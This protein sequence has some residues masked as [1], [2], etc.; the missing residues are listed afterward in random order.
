MPTSFRP[1]QSLKNLWLAV[2]FSDKCTTPSKGFSNGIVDSVC[3]RFQ[4]AHRSYAAFIVCMLVVAGCSVSSKT[5]YY[6]LSHLPDKA[7]TSSAD[8]VLKKASPLYLGI[9]PLQVAKY[10]DR[11]QIVVRTNPHHIQVKEFHH[12][13]GHIDALI[14]MAVQENLST[15]L[16]TDHIVRY[17]WNR[18]RTPDVQLKID[19]IEMDG[20]PEKGVRLIARWQ[21][22]RGGNIKSAKWFKS[23]I[24]EPITHG[25]VSDLAQAHSKAVA[26]FCKIM[27]TAVLK[28]SPGA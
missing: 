17:P 27:A 19:V 12:W 15:L 24:F 9:G 28:E 7:V 20:N 4:A 21:L 5:H 11:P 22:I 23:D 3:S 26:K 10:L 8:G 18:S 14:Y 16:S 2:G 25:D 13:A 1:H 6:T